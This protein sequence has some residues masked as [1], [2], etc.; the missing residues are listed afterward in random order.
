[1]EILLKPST[2]TLCMVYPALW[3]F[4]PEKKLGTVMLIDLSTN[5][6]LSMKQK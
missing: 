1:M 4:S 5:L 3:L 6:F 2:L